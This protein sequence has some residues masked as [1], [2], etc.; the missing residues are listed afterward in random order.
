MYDETHYQEGTGSAKQLQRE[1][2]AVPADLAV[3]IAAAMPDLEE[4]WAAG[5]GP[6]PSEPPTWPWS[7]TGLA[8]RV[9]E[10]RNWLTARG[11]AR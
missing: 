11:T 3:V 4:Q 2:K 5:M 8:A 1:H 6:P 7:E 9:R 10:A